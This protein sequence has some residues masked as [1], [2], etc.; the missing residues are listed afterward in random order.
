MNYRS[1]CIFLMVISFSSAKAAELDPMPAWIEAEINAGVGTLRGYSA[2]ASVTLSPW[3]PIYESEPKVRFNAAQS[4]YRFRDDPADATLSKGRDTALDL[5]VGYGYH[6]DWWSLLG[7]VGATAPR[8]VM[9]PVDSP[10]SD[11]TK[12]G[13]KAFVALD[14]SP[15]EQTLFFAQGNYS[16]VTNAYFVQAQFGRA[17][18]PNVFIGP[19]VSFSR[20]LDYEQRRVGVF[21]FGSFGCLLSELSVGY[22]NDHDQGAG[23]YVRTSVWTTF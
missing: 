4:V 1:I 2:E 7:M 17:V 10:F 5:L 15:S 14:A 11:T 12:F 22:V 21:M 3:S 20:G 18:L 16:T 19:E 9:R 13:A 8:S 6:A 23:A